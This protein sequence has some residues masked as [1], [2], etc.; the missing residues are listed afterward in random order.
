MIAPFGLDHFDTGNS[1]VIS[2]DDRDLDP[3]IENFFQ[4][5]HTIEHYC[6]QLAQQHPSQW[7]WDY[8]SET[9]QLKSSLKGSLFR[10]KIRPQ[11]EIYDETS[12]LCGYNE[13][14]QLLTPWC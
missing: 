6:H 5:I 13:G 7:D 2:F 8:Q 14:C 4:F 11:T 1:C 3:N 12:Q 10:I 9:L